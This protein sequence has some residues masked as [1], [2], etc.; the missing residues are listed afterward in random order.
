M[1]TTKDSFILFLYLSLVGTYLFY[2]IKLIIYFIIN[3]GFLIG[4]FAAIVMFFLTIL[5][6]E[7]EILSINHVSKIF[8]FKSDVKSKF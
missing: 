7:K 6:I 8:D 5:G 1:L 2:Y 3:Y 4:L